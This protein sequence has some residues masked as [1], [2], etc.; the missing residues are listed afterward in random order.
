MPL[1]T[2]IQVFLVGSLGGCL[3]EIVHWW[4]LR[5]R[6]PRFPKYARSLFY[7]LVT[8]LMALSGGLL[9]VLYF[10]DQAEAIVA[11]H[12]GIS[13]PLIL[14]KLAST[15]AEPGARAEV[16]SGLKDFISW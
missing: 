6:N 4:N 7:W 8:V 11:L 5:R 12:V 16:T 14:Q 1:T 9:A 15:M 3:L 2:F 13:A 10:G